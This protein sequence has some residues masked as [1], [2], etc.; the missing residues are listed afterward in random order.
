[1]FNP[2]VVIRV[3]DTCSWSIIWTLEKSVKYAQIKNKGSRKTSVRSYWCLISHNVS[4][5]F[6]VGCEQ[7]AA[8]LKANWSMGV[9]EFSE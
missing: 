8:F 3:K 1:M 2:P 6:I 7:V 9:L 5:T 4:D